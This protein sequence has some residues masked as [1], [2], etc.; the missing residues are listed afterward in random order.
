MYETVYSIQYIKRMQKTGD[1]RDS[2]QYTAYKQNE[3]AM[4]SKGAELNICNNSEM[5]HIPALT[6]FISSNIT[7]VHHINYYI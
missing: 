5:K 6:K 3:K 1:V 7:I 4:N 2:M